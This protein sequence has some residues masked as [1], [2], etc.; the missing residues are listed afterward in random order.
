MPAAPTSTTLSMLAGAYRCQQLQKHNNVGACRCRHVPATQKHTTLLMPADDCKCLQLQQAPH[1]R[2][3]HVPTDAC[4]SKN[5]HNV[6]ACRC[7]Q[8]PATRALRAET[9]AQGRSLQAMSC[10]LYC[11]AKRQNSSSKCVFQF[12]SAYFSA[13]PGARARRRGVSLLARHPVWA[14][15]AT[16]MLSLPRLVVGAPPHLSPF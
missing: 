2:C 13:S 12:Q 11:L 7:R 6:G 10:V 4:R 8:V 5:H 16:T 9:L 14:A 1:C 3:L 15:S